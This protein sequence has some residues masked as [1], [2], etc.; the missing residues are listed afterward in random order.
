MRIGLQLPPLR[1]RAPAS[2]L[3]PLLD[4]RA[5][6][7]PTVSIVL[8]LCVSALLPPIVLTVMNATLVALALAVVVWANERLDPRLW[9]L[10]VPFVAMIFIGLASGVGAELYPYFKDAWYVGNP[11]LVIAT[12]YVLFVVRPDLN[13]G[14]RAFVVGGL[15]VSLWQL[16]AYYFAPELLLLPADTI[17]RSVGTGHYAPVLALVIMLLMLGR[18]KAGLRLPAWLVGV[19]FVIVAAAVAGVFSRTALMVVLIALAAWLGCFARREWLRVGLPLLLLLCL[20]LLLQIFVD[21]ESDR[22]LKTFTG[23]LARTLNELT[24]SDY[25]G[26]RDINLS[27]RGH[28]TAQ[29]LLQFATSSLP[30]ML[31]GRGFAATVDLGVLLPIELNEAGERVNVRFITLLHNGYLFLLTKTG[32]AGLLLYLYALS[33]LYLAGRPLAALPPS[34]PRRYPAR[35]LQACAVTLAATTYI[36]GGVFNKQD[37]FPFMLLTGYLLAWVRNHDDPA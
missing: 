2:R 13:A 25:N 1:Q 22:A 17:R 27:F 23:K 12:G 21:I 5:A 34:D 11:L 10:M 26:L 32:V 30:E 19:A 31:F 24:V 7:W 8:L 18:W 4:R 33:I 15:I 28:E 16:R 37:L 29:A 36:V 14:L 9:R 6:V 3:A 35:L 20:G